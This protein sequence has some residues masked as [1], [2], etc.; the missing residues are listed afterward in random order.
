MKAEWKVSDTGSAH[1][2]CLSFTKVLQACLLL[3]QQFGHTIIERAID[4]CFLPSFSSFGWE[5]SE[6]K[7]KMRKVNGRRMPKAHI[8]FG[9]VS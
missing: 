7:I 6:E 8:A 3:L 4:R 2:Y 9:K 1:L 5:V